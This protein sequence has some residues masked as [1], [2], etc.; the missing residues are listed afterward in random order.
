MGPFS[1][2]AAPKPCPCTGRSAPAK[3]LLLRPALRSWLS[4]LERPTR[5]DQPGSH[6]GHQSLDQ[7]GGSVVQLC[8]LG[9]PLAKGPAWRLPARRASS[10]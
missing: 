8:R 9:W 1:T 5:T 2:L 10:S 4:S 7:L 3:S 6:A